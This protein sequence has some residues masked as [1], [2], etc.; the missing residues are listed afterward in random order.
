M[1]NLP[2]TL[3]L[4][5][6]VAIPVFLISLTNGHPGTALAIFMAAGM[7]DA[8]DGALARLTGTQSEFGATLDPLADKLLMVSSFIVLAWYDAVPSWLTIIVLTREVVLLLGYW[9]IFFVSQPVQ[10]RPSAI[11]KVNTFFQLF[12][13]GF[14]LLTMARPD[15]PMAGVNLVTQSITAAT[16]TAS[17]VQYVYRGLLWQQTH[18]A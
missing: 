6:V 3:T 14:A 15:L 4:L 8:V 11:G 17:G 10:V 12:T 7:T 16:T 2:N 18:A 9:V 1:L 13:V 5:R